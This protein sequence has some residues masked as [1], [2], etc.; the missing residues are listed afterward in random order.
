MSYP[1]KCVTFKLYM[2]LT[3]QVFHPSIHYHGEKDYFIFF[4]SVSAIFI[5]YFVLCTSIC[6]KLE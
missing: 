3:V 2:Y 6:I 1:M 4:I 5:N